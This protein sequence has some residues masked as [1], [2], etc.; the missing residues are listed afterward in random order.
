VSK[1]LGVRSGYFSIFLRTSL[2]KIEFTFV[3]KRK[4][5][6]FFNWKKILTGQTEK[7]LWIVEFRLKNPKEN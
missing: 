1:V 3:A 7:F 2:G 6:Q 5:D 4:T